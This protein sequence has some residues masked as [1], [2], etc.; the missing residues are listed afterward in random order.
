M[1]EMFGRLEDSFQIGTGLPAEAFHAPGNRLGTVRGE[2]A[3]MFENER[4][5]IGVGQ[6][7]LVPFKG[8]RAI[9]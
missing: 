3:N 6:N 4:Q 5:S 7:A 1:N 9:E 2:L 8:N